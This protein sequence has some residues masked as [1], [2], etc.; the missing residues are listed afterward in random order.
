MKK[1]ILVGGAICL[2]LFGGLLASMGSQQTD[3]TIKVRIARLEISTIATV[4]MDY[5][6][7]RGKFLFKDMPSLYEG[8]DV[9]KA[10]CPAYA[11]SL[12]TRDPWGEPYKVIY[13]KEVAKFYGFKTA[14]EDDYL[15]ISFG[16]DKK[17]E[18]WT[19]DPKR[20]EA[21]IYSGI[22]PDK[23]LVNFNGSFIRGPKKI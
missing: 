23:D 1:S 6:T 19:Y 15:V 2:F 13:G 4:L 8:S 16:R 5:L 9:Y 11:K 17:M 12:P 10:L 7:D 3:E 20:P 21:G 18:K 22:D 14:A